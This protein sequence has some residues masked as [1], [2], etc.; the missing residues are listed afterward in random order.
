MLYSF[1]RY[2]FRRLLEVVMFFVF[3]TSSCAFSFPD[4]GSEGFRGCYIFLFLIR[5]VVCCFY[6]LRTKAG[7]VHD[8]SFD[9]QV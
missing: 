9:R 2:R 4:T 3:D 8:G 5:V 6:I 1:S 7:E